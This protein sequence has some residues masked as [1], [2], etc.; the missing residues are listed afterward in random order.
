ME[1]SWNFVRPK[2]YEP[3]INIFYCAVHSLYLNILNK[4]IFNTV[5][6]SRKRSSDNSAFHSLGAADMKDK[7]R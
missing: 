5:I 4:L 2:V 3:C 1:K 6:S 7:T